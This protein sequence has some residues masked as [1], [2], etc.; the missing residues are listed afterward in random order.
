MKKKRN[1]RDQNQKIEKEKSR[2]IE[3]EKNQK[4]KNVKKVKKKRNQIC[5]LMKKNFKLG[6]KSV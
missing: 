4:I 3:N 5:H 1:E 6:I 2:M